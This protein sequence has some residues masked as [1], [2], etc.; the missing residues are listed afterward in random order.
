MRTP[1]QDLSVLPSKPLTVAKHVHIRSLVGGLFTR[2]RGVD[3]RPLGL[4]LT[5]APWRVDRRGHPPHPS[6]PPRTKSGEPSGLGMERAAHP[7]RIPL[8]VCLFPPV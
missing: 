6:P 7:H 3:E 4:G 2:H 8:P 5:V 1:R